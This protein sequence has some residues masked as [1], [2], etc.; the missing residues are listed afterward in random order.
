[1]EEQPKVRIEFEKSPH[2]RL[3]PADGAWGGPTPRGRIMVNF[4]VDIPS[5]P[6]SI[7]HDLTEDGQLGTELE[8]SPAV[9]GTIPRVARELQVGVLLSL[10]D[11]E[12][13][14]RW[15]LEQVEMLRSEGDD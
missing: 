9:D 11:A 10:E 14:G 6:Y 8:R 5:A 1:M 15:L 7:T 2:Y 12:G 3:M 4:F 13:V